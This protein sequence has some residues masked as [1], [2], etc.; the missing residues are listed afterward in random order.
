MTRLRTQWG[1][2]LV[3]YAELFGTSAR[4]RLVA[5]SEPFI[6]RGQLC[7]DAHTLKLSSQGVFTSDEIIAELFD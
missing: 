2:D 1:I 6:H 3:D 5:L 7:L 4:E